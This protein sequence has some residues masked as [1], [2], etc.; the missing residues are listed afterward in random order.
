MAFLFY[1][2]NIDALSDEDQPKYDFFIIF[3]FQEK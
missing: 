1:F 3:Y 2:Y